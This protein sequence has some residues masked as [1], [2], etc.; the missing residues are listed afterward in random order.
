MAERKPRARLIGS[1]SASMVP[2]RD[3]AFVIIAPYLGSTR[4]ASSTATVRRRRR[5]SISKSV[6]RWSSRRRRPRHEPRSV[7]QTDTKLDLVTGAFS[8][9]GSHIA[10]RLVASGTQVRTS[11][12]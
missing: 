1:V 12:P 5:S 4:S 11:K 10:A 8:Y 2:S 9:S 3:L 6:M 7:D